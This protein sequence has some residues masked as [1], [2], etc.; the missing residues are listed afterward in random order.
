MDRPDK[1]KGRPEKTPERHKE[2]GSSTVAVTQPSAKQLLDN[3]GTVWLFEQR[4]G[5]RV[6]YAVEHN[7]QVWRFSLYFSARAKFERE[8]AKY[9]RTTP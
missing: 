7:D 9:G 5:A 4:E 3:Y 1:E 6:S 8:I 2:S